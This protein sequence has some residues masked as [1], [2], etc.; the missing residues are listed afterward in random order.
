MLIPDKAPGCTASSNVEHGITILRRMPAERGFNINYLVQT[1][2]GSFQ[3]CCGSL[4][5][6]QIFYFWPF[7]TVEDFAS[8]YNISQ[9]FSEISASLGAFALYRIMLKNTLPP[10]LSYYVAKS[11]RIY[12]CFVNCSDRVTQ[13]VKTS[14]AYLFEYSAQLLFNIEYGDGRILPLRYLV[15]YCK[16][17]LC[18]ALWL[19]ID[20]SKQCL[21]PWVT[22]SVSIRH[23]QGK[24][25]KKKK[26]QRAVLCWE[27]LLFYIW[28]S[29]HPV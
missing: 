19:Q 23:F 16:T 6:L 7:C 26:E 1:W 8:L 14:K 9:C 29:V 13:N 10:N 18:E 22:P 3:L 17:A 24:D 4:C 15:L 2:G 12:I 20:E 11:P 25:Q 27:A 5:S 21:L 28:S